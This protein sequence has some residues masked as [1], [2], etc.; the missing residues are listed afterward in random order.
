VFDV[1]TAPSQVWLA[2]GKRSIPVGKD[3]EEGVWPPLAEVIRRGDGSEAWV[4]ADGSIYERK[5]A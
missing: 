3:Y 4:W 5:A 1:G 2:R